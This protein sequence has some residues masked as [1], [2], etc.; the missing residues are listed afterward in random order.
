MP[1][2]GTRYVNLNEPAIEP[3][4][5]ALANTELF[6][7]LSRRMGYADERLHRSDNERIRLMLATGHP[8]IE[9]ITYES[10]QKSGGQRLILATS[11]PGKKAVSGARVVNANSFL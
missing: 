10:L 5:E 3:E 11:I 4:G 7:V 1:S 2:W 6:R 9:G 8:Y